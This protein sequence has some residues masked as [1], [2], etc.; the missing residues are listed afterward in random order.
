[1]AQPNVHIHSSHIEKIEGQTIYT[2]DGSK[3]EIDV[4]ILATGFRGS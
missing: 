4:L 1:M 2:E 3:V